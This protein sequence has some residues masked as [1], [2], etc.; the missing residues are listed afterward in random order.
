MDLYIKLGLLLVMSIAVDASDVSDYIPQIA[1]NITTNITDRTFVLVQPNCIFNQYTT[2]NVWVV[3]ALNKSFSNL[4][5]SD[6]STPVPYS[7]FKNGLYDYYHTLLVSGGKYPCSTGDSASNKVILIGSETCK[8]NT[9]CNGVLS[10]NQTY[11]VKFILLNSTGIFDKTQWSSEII[12]QKDKSLL[13][14]NVLPSGRSGGMI[15]LTSILSVLL[16]ILLVSVIAA[17]ALGSRD[18]CW[19]RSVYNE[20]SVSSKMDFMT[21]STY[22]SR[23]D[24]MYLVS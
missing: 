24:H 11:R 22:R 1:Q 5:D 12:L 16:A 13:G 9:F 14:L 7:S 10:N 3:I 15:V 20:K 21:H 2:T 17:L 18:I 23:Y 6:F 8:D 19:K 4:K